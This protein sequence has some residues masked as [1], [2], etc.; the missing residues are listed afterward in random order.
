MHLQCTTIELTLTSACVA[1]AMNSKK[2]ISFSVIIILCQ[3]VI[4]GRFLL[5]CY[6]SHNDPAVTI[7]SSFIVTGYQR[8]DDVMM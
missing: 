5:A 2:Q 6:T 3:E 8:F 1:V 4:S 7:A